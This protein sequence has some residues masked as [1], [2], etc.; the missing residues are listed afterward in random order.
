MNSGAARDDEVQLARAVR[1]GDRGDVDGARTVLGQLESALPDECRVEGCLLDLRDQRPT[2]PTLAVLDEVLARSDGRPLLRGRA[3][4]VK[5]RIL[6]RVADTAGA[7][8]CLLDALASYADAGA[9]E[10]AAAV[11]DTLGMVFAFEG[12]LEPAV[13][14]YAI[15]LAEKLVGEDR[16]G[17]AITLGQIGRLQLRA[18]RA[19]EARRCFELDRRLAEEHDDIRG[20]AQMWNDIARTYL[21]EERPTEALDAVAHSLEM[22]DGHHLDEIAI[23]A[24]KDR[25]LALVQHARISEVSGAGLDGA[26]EAVQ[27]GRRLLRSRHDAF[28]AAL[29]D[30]AEG[31]VLEVRGDPRAA[32]LLQ[33]AAASL[34]TLRAPDFEIP[35]LL[36][37]AAARVRV[38]EGPRAHAALVRALT[39][40]RSDGLARYLAPIREAMARLDLPEGATIEQG[41]LD[42]EPAGQPVETGYAEL[43]SIGDGAFGAVYRAL[44]LRRNREV[45]IKRLRLESLYDAEEH[46]T[47][48]ASIRIELQATARIRHPGIARVLA[49]GTDSHGG[50]YVVQELVPGSS[51]A[52]EMRAEPIASA[53]RVAAFGRDVAHALD[54]LHDVDVVHRDLKPANVILSIPSGRPVLVDMGVAYV[55]TNPESFGRRAFVGSLPYMAPEQAAGKPIDGRADVFALGVVLYEWLT[56]FHPIR[57]RPG[58]HKAVARQLAHDRAEPLDSIR[59]DAPTGL[60]K[61]IHRML[62]KSPRRRPSARE[63]AQTLDAIVRDLEAETA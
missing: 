54:A 14:Y 8:S 32:A 57:V 35:A 31:M 47:R 45:A 15:S 63:V 40:A 38:G 55:P 51:L 37:L 49:I 43:R 33:A 11:Y 36:D 2:Q 16:C 62:E 1:M 7:A 28:A 48:D 44:D 12:Q 23:F 27:E 42:L 13:A 18:G 25:A 58:D 46:R 6:A 56:G 3:L 21:M 4:H 5:G 50:T 24:H 30:H 17:A 29:L 20:Q 61:Y 22:A 39:L 9:S 60:A 26:L 19:R 53:S 34:S 10:R 41:R 59:P 52:A